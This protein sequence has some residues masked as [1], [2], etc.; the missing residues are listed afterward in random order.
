MFRCVEADVDA[1]EFSVVVVGHSGRRRNSSDTTTATAHR[2]PAVLVTKTDASVEDDDKHHVF[3]A[4]GV[5]SSVLVP[6]TCPVFRFELLILFNVITTDSDKASLLIMCR[7]VN[8]HNDVLW[9]Q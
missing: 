2:H 1:S 5:E 9:R 8:L 7:L 6:K 3:E 4:S